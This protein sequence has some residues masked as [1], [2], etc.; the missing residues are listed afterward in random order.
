MKSRTGSPNRHS[1]AA[2]KKNLR[3]RETREVRAKATRSNF[4][5]PLVIVT[6]LNGIGV[7]PLRMMIQAPHCAKPP[8]SASYLSIAW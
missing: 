5:T 4:A 3:L 1:K 7:S 8:F 2:S 6:S